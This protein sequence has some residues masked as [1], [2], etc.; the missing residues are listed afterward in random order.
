M[1]RLPDVSIKLLLGLAF[2]SGLSSCLRDSLPDCPP[3]SITLAV[4]DKNYFNIDDAVKLGL[5]ERKADNLPFREYVHTLY[6]IIH[7]AEGNVVLEQKN[8][9]VANDEQTQVITLP[10]DLPYGKYTVTAWG[11]MESEEPLGENATDAE[12]EAVGAASND[13]Y[14]TSGV[15]DYRY[16][17]EQ[18]TLQMER[19]KGNLLIKAEGIPDNIDFSTKSIEDIYGRVDASFQYSTLTDIR[20]ELEWEVRNEIQSQTL[21]CPSPSYEGTT[22]GVSF[23]DRSAVEERQSSSRAVT[24][25]PMLTPEDV[26]IT[27]GRNE[28]TILKYVYD[29]S[30]DDF[31]IFV[32]VD[33]RW[34]EIHSMEID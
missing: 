34:E 13:I 28:I 2:T 22:L 32:R 31:D 1:N 5:A 3:L 21:M 6:Y 16:G 15:L 7:D 9:Q 25:S 14:L 10:S 8:A 4:K 24:T 12:M 11:N 33:D 18:H 29:D 19:T 30:E 23:I 26:H 20:T 17:N 27:M